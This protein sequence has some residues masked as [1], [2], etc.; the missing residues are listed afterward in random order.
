M[1]GKRGAG[2]QLTRE[3]HRSDDEDETNGNRPTRASQDVLAKRKILKPKG[4]LGKT[5]NANAPS[6]GFQFGA[7]TTTEA[8]PSHKTNVFGGFGQS[9]SAS[10][11]APAPA[12]PFGGFG[13]STEDK[14]ANTFSMFGSRPAEDKPANAFG[15]F[16][17]KKDE[18][19][20][21]VNAFASF[22]KPQP[23]STASGVFSM[24]NKQESLTQQQS[25]L[26]STK[27]VE[28]ASKIKALND[29]FYEKITEERTSNPVSNFTPILRKYIDYYDKIDRDVEMEDVDSHLD[30]KTQK[31]LPASPAQMAQGAAASSSFNFGNTDKPSFNFASPAPSASAPAS[32]GFN[33]SAPVTTATTTTTGGPSFAFGSK[34][35]DKEPTPMDESQDKSMTKEDEKKVDDVVVDVHSEDSDSD[36]EVKVEGPTFTLSKPLTTTDS[37]FK[38]SN[39]APREKSSGSGPTFTF[40]STGKSDSVFKFSPVE[41]KPENSK[42]EEKKK[43]T[44]NP[45]PATGT[46]SN[47]FSWSPNKQA[48][49]KKTDGTSKPTFNFGQTAEKKDESV[50]P[51]TSFAGFSMPTATDNG[52]TKAAPLFNFS[53][54]VTSDKPTTTTSFNFGAPSAGATSAVSS[55]FNFVGSTAGSSSMSFNFGSKPVELTNGNGSGNGTGDD[56]QV[57]AP[58]PDVH[59]KPLVELKEKVTTSSGEEDEV[60]LYTKRSK[61]LHYNVG[62]KKY[63]TRGVGE[64][65]LLQHKETKKCR[66]LLRSEGAERVI[67]NTAVGKTL[68]YTN[69]GKGVRV[70]VFENGKLETYVLRV[71]TDDD[72]NEMISVID[73]AKKQL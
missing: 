41:K 67:L 6:A 30:V 52:A 34:P 16:A 42:P 36:D 57:D 27:S 32:T 48:D 40:T 45:A 12:N 35:L 56:D 47:S 18:E 3:N 31:A 37:V 9:A 53:A 65:R 63:D 25:S 51:T 29:T 73:E 68:E 5:G 8:E 11:A 60:A 14:P 58:E 7:K 44:E 4:R 72:A 1:S 33:F 61:L 20:P 2:E 39:D 54:P 19:K 49:E 10:P 50:K 26:T 62:D 59:I 69:V 28:K 21:A 71:K 24:V 43:A 66:L 13:K 17:P 38:L 64:V 55:G 70:P 46:T 23:A 15:M 22:T